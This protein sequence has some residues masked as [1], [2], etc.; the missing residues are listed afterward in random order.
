MK[1]MDAVIIA[2]SH[3]EFLELD[4]AKIDSLFANVG[5]K[6]ILMDLK[7]ILDR[8]TYEAKKDYIYWRL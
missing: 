2:V 6:K 3:K 1:D 7:G 8:A 4:V 5:E